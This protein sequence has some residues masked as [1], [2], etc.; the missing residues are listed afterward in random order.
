MHLL[1]RVRAAATANKYKYLPNASQPSGSSLI[2]AARCHHLRTVLT[3]HS[4]FRCSVVGCS[5]RLGHSYLIQRS[6]QGKFLSSTA[7]PSTSNSIIINSGRAVMLEPGLEDI[8]TAL[9]SLIT[10]ASSLQ[11]RQQQQLEHVRDWARA[12][13]IDPDATPALHVAGTKGKGSV[14]AYTECV[15]RRAGLKTGLFTSPHLMTVRERFRINGAAIDVD[16]FRAVFWDV[17]GKMKQQQQM[18]RTSGDVLSEP[19]AYFRFLTLL[20]FA[21]FKR[22]NVDVSVIEVGL[23][24]RLDATNIMSAPAACCITSL[25]MDHMA[26]LGKTLDKIAFEKAG[27]LKPNVP[28]VLTPQKPEA[29]AVVIARAGEVPCSIYRSGAA[30]CR[31]P[32]LMRLLQQQQPV[33][34]ENMTAA[35]A[36][37]ALA[38]LRLPLKI[39]SKSPLLLEWRQQLM[40]FIPSAAYLS[41]GSGSGEQQHQVLSLPPDAPVPEWVVDA[42]Q[43]H[44]PPRRTNDDDDS[45]RDNSTSHENDHIITI[46]FDSAVSLLALYCC[47]RLVNGRVECK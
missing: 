41:S 39:A 40:Q 1:P 42:L 34:A 16:D 6:L 10:N 17:W 14:C 20:G 25:G 2:S 35:V 45:N 21:A 24:G 22:L 44:H 13:C 18:D 29:D 37:S 8:N 47:F 26:V 30:F 38:A 46:A 43:V 7:A 36:L 11:C 33:V 3:G 12:L 27:I 15:L 9:G 4:V 31:S 28:C 19:P 32:N 23:G 5:S